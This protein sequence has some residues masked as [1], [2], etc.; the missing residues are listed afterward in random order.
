MVGDLVNTTGAVA[1]LQ[2]RLPDTHFV[3]EGGAPARE[4]F[5]GLEVWRRRRGGLPGKLRRILRYRAGKFDTALVLD[6]SREALRLVRLAGIPSI[7]GGP[8]SRPVPVL[9]PEIASHDH[10]APL[11]S[12]I[13]S[14]AQ[15]YGWAFDPSDL[16]PRLPIPDRGDLIPGWI[17]HVTASDRPKEWPADRWV[18][19]ARQQECWI[20]GGPGDE[21]VVRR[22]ARES[23]RPALKSMSLLEYAARIAQAPGLVCA[24]TG[25]AHLA[26]AVGTRTV[27]LYGPTDPLCFHPWGDRW[28]ALRKEAK[29]A[30]YSGGCAF[31][32]KGQCPQTC[33]RSITTADVLL[34]L[35]Q[36]AGN[37]E[38][39]SDGG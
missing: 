16:R 24:D 31:S 9:P 39:S 3:L 4:I 28:A 8:V 33:M 1:Y 29:C 15:E 14:I 20:A 21:E 10:F 11:A 17:F 34:E 37:V 6:D 2:A 12:A 22:I 23:G 18:D 30:H 26:A 38:M 13:A 7:Y 32:V 25:P 27:V 5:P 36:I 19:L 35:R